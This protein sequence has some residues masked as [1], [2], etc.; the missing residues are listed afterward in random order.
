M[1]GRELQLETVR[2]PLLRCCHHAGVVDQA[3]DR[4]EGAGLGGR[5]AHGREIG[6]VD[7]QP[8]QGRR[9]DLVGDLALGLGNL[10]VGAPRQHHPGT[11]PGELEGGVE[12]QP[13]DG[14]AGDQHGPTA[15]VGHVVDVPA[16]GHGVT[17]REAT[18]RCPSAWSP[19]IRTA[20]FAGPRRP[21]A[22]SMKQPRLMVSRAVGIGRW[23]EKL[24]TAAPVVDRAGVR[25][26][27]VDLEHDGRAG[28]CADLLGHHEAQALGEVVG[29]VDPGRAVQ[30]AG[31]PDRTAYVLLVHPDVERA[32]AQQLLGRPTDH[33]EQ[34]GRGRRRIGGRVGQQRGVTR[35]GGGADLVDQLVG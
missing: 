30:V 27:T 7:H 8:R 29:R 24:L 6:E 10:A 17:A 9:G 13:A 14:A 28:G 12:P 4:A 19:S 35:R 15:L 3:V 33:A 31:A 20:S 5:A 26:V 34:A 21:P 2:G 1:V 16:A 25:R 32:V 18:M 11:S 22:S 23:L